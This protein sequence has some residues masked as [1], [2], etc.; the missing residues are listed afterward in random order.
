MDKKALSLKFMVN[1]LSSCFRYFPSACCTSDCFHE[2]LPEFLGTSVCLRLEW[3]DSAIRKT[4]FN[5]KRLNVMVLKREQ[6]SVRSKVARHMLRI[7][8]S[9]QK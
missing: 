6:L 2:T 3:S 7:F 1:L 9:T 4:N 8:P 5:C